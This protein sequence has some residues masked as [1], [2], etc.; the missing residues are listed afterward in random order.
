[1][2]IK[3]DLKEIIQQVNKKFVVKDDGPIDL[4]LESSDCQFTLKATLHRE[5]IVN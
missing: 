2:S 1:M 3:L 4:H 5:K